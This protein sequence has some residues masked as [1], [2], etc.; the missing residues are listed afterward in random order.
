MTSIHQQIFAI[1]DTE[2]HARDFLLQKN[3]LK[4]TMLCPSCSRS[5]SQTSCPTTK[6]PDLLIWRCSPCQKYKNIRSDSVISGQKLSQSCKLVCSAN[7]L[8]Q[9]QKHGY[10]IDQPADRYIIKYNQWMEGTTSYK[11]CK[12]ADQFFLVP[13]YSARSAALQSAALQSATR[14]AALQYIICRQLISGGWSA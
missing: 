10:I 5:M 7:I 3:I 13:W 8:P 9:H 2:E 1:T 12:L 6:S 11:N 14:S 4:A